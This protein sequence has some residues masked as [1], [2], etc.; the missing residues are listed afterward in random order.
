MIH[1]PAGQ[2]KKA[3][4]DICAPA[5]LNRLPAGKFRRKRKFVQTGHASVW[6]C[7][8]FV[9]DEMTSRLDQ[10]SL[11]RGVQPNQNTAFHFHF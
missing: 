10:H 8:I 4:K 2:Y 5:S 9:G 3:L 6:Y 7:P 11:R 1:D